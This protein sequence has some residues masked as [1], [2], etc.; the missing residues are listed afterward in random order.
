MATVYWTPRALARAQIS[1]ASIDSLDATP[2]NNTFTVTVGGFSVSVVGDSGASPPDAQTTAAALVAALVSSTQ[3]YIAAIG[4]TAP[5]AGVIRGTS[6]AGVPFVAALTET[7]AGTG[8]V[9][10][11]ADT[12]TATSPHHVNEVLNW[13]TGALPAVNDDVVIADSAISLLWGLTALN[14]LSRDSILV[15]R[16]FT[17]R[18][19]LDSTRFAT[20][21]DSVTTNATVPEYR[22]SYLEVRSP[23]VVSG[24]DLG[25]GSSS[26]SSRIK[27]NNVLAA[28]SR[29]LV[30]GTAATSDG[31]RPAFRYLAA[32]A[33]AVLEVLEAPGGVGVAAELPGETST[34]SRVEMLG[35]SSASRIIIG[36]GAAVTTYLQSTGTAT[37]ANGATVN[38]SGGELNIIGED[39]V[40]ALTV[41]GGRVRDRHTR[42]AGSEWTAITVS[43]GVLDLSGSGEARTVDALTHTGGQI[44]ADWGDLTIT[45]HVVPSGRAS[46]TV[47]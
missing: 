18:I 34:L 1:D 4:W 13:S 16:S 32:H 10:D 42:S 3:P 27:I 25:I 47:Q 35:A 33:S 30:E 44:D 14:A 24:R 15:A 36:A 11:F 7:G 43:G 22:G 5:G 46:I 17:G 29:A 45:A 41:S 21:V 37:I 20:S 39:Y 23:L 2:A 28:A 8:A 26:G 12:Q 40:L 38:V 19:G 9:T 6:V 31:A